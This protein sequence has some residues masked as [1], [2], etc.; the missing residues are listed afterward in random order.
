MKLSSVEGFKV[1]RCVILPN[2]VTV[3]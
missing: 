1:V 2:F 3:V